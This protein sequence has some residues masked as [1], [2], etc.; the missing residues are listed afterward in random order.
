MAQ[1]TFQY[2]DYLKLKSREFLDPLRQ[3]FDEEHVQNTCNWQLSGTKGGLFPCRLFVQNA[4]L[5]W[6]VLP[7]YVTR[8]ITHECHSLS[9][10]HQSN[11]SLGNSGVGGGS[12]SNTRSSGSIVFMFYVK[13]LFVAWVNFIAMKGSLLREQW[14]GKDVQVSAVTLFKVLFP[15]YYFQISTLISLLPYRL[16]SRLILLLHNLPLIFD[17]RSS[18]WNFIRQYYYYNY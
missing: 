8:P 3:A 6:W 7:A 16:V 15:S 9:H 12:K 10:K 4:Q 5:C 2:L 14:S 11:F 17:T 13:T 1:D 18:F